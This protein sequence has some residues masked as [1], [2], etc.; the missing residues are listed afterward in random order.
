MPT[1]TETA[2]DAYKAALE[3]RLAAMETAISLL[4]PGGPISLGYEVYNVKT[5]GALGNGIADDTAAIQAAINACKTS[6]YHGVVYL[7]PGTYCFS[8]LNLSNIGGGFIL[9]GDGW[10]STRLM[11]IGH[12][13][14][15]TATGHLLDCSGSKLK[16]ESL[17]IGA[18]NQVPIPTT[19]IFMSQS[20]TNGADMVHLSDLYIS[21][22]YSTATIYNYGVPSG[23]MTRCQIYNY[24][25][26]AS[27][28]VAIFTKTNISGLASDFA[29]VPAP[30]ANISM[31]DWTFSANEFHRFGNLSAGICV[32]LDDVSNFTFLGGNITAGG[33]AYIW[34]NG[35]C[36]YVYIIGTTF[37]T[38]SQPMPANTI[39]VIG[40]LNIHFP[41][42]HEDIKPAPIGA[43]YGGSGAVTPI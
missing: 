24:L 25:S 38:E 4:S 16:I 2:A 27:Q 32:V 11:A 40:T 39:L 10:N 30:F 26:A 17:Q 34:A 20:S 23:S 5:Y 28:Y 22:S 21:G 7:P 41:A 14:Y 35:T 36:K 42:T 12:S 1:A 29:T 33:A 6:T 8:R 18:F 31:S 37:E 3:S 19:A 9:R 43:R 13:S 15:G